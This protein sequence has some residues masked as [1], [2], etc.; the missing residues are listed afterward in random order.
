MKDLHWYH[1]PP[2]RQNGS[3]C[4][5]RFSSGITVS[6]PGRSVS[7][8]RIQTG[9][10]RAATERISIEIRPVA[11]RYFLSTSNDTP[12]R[13]S[14]ARAA[15]F[16]NTRQCRSRVRAELG[17][18]ARV[19]IAM[20]ETSRHRAMNVSTGLC[21]GFSE[22]INRSLARKAD[23]ESSKVRRSHCVVAP[24]ACSLLAGVSNHKRPIARNDSWF[25]T[26]YLILFWLTL[27][28]HFK[29]E[30]Q[31]GNFIARVIV[32]VRQLRKAIEQLDFGWRALIDAWKKIDQVSPG[33]ARRTESDDHVAL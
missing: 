23:A 5:A 6:K 18:A 19:R 32:R 3:P 1:S 4:A 16:P 7:G 31:R 26:A 9:C 21:E 24:L 29:V 33:R 17:W 20:A 30:V 22:S 27:A 2:S 11:I 14:A 13:S 10:I 28:G 15:Y 8:M 25:P 12:T